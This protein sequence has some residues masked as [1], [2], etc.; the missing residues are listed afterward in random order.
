MM[1]RIL[2]C[3]VAFALVGLAFAEEKKETPKLTGTWVREH[4]GMEITFT[5]EEKTASISVMIGDNGMTAST[6]YTVDKD[7]IVK[8]KVTKV[9][10]KGTFPA[11]PVKGFEFSMKVKVDGKKA[12]VSEFKSEHEGAAAIIEGEYKQKS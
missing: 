12:M 10:E 5:F 2:C 7:G 4:D 8:A 1:S 6:D 9:E 11:K 3:L